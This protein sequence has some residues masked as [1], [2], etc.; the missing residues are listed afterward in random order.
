[1]SET[2]HDDMLVGQRDQAISFVS[3]HIAPPLLD[4]TET[5]PVT[6]FP[7]GNKSAQRIYA[8]GFKSLTKLKYWDADGDLTADPNAE[9]LAAAWGAPGRTRRVFWYGPVRMAGQR[10]W[11]GRRSSSST[12]RASVWCRPG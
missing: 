10:T 9:V 8:P 4:V 3:Q 11:I 5:C 2:D 1:M 12:S 7:K 6:A